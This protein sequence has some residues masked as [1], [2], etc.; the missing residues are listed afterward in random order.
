M[1]VPTANAVHIDYALSDLSVAYLQEK[2]PIS[3]LIFPRVSV[4]HQSNKYF[5]WNKGD[6]LRDDAQKRA[7]GADFAQTKIGLTTDSYYCDQFGL[8]YPVYDEIVAN[9]DASVRL[10]QNATRVLTSR[11][12]MKKDRAFAAD[13]LTTSVWGTD[14]TGVAAA[15]GASQTLQWNDATSDPAGDLQAAMEA[16][17]NATGDIEGLRYKLLIGSA[18][19]AALVNHPDA[20]DRVKYTEKADVAAVDGVLGAW[21]GVDDLIVGRRRYTTSVENQTDTFAA[22]FGKVALLVAVPDA[23]G[24]ETPSAGYTFEW[25][26]PGKGPMYVEQYRWEKTKADM[27]RAVTYFDQKAVASALGY[28]FTSIVA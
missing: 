7:P 22:V 28:F 18:V 6:F 2:P 14:I 13:F 12:N 27:V 21:L 26:E 1:P 9:E 8:E 16:L 25:S 15:P 4:D 19:R 5:L 23:P 11:L 20:I 10:K 17:L 24:L 3:D